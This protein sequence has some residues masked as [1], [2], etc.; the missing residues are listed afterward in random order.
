MKLINLLF[1]LVILTFQVSFSQVNTTKDVKEFEAIADTLFKYFKYDSASVYYRKAAQ[2]YEKEQDWLTC[3][4]NYRL[5]SNALLKAAKYDTALYYTNKALT[6][7]ETYFLK[8]NKDEMFEKSDV[9]INLADADEKKGKYEEELLYCKK[10]LALTLKT[11]SLASLRIANIWDKIGI[12]YTNLGNYSNALQFCASALYTKIKLLGE[13]HINVAESN[14]NIGTIY[15]NKGEY[16]KALAYLQKALKN[17]IATLGEQQPMTADIYINFGLVYYKKGEYDKA[18]EYYQNALKIHIATLGELHPDVAVNYYFIGN[19]YNHKGEYDKALEYYQKNLKKYIALLGER[20]PYFTNVYSHVGAVYRNKGEY[21]KALEYLQKAIIIGIATLGEQHPLIANFYNN[22]GLVYYMKGEYDKALVYY[23]NALKIFIAAFGEQHLDV[24]WSYNNIGELFHVKEL[25]D[26]SLEYFQKALK[27]RIAILGELNPFVAD[28][29]IKIGARYFNKGDYDTSLEYFQK[30]LKINIATLGEKHPDVAWN[31]NIIGKANRKKGE[32]FKALQNYQKALIANLTSFNDTSIY[33]NPKLENVLSKPM[34]LFSL[35]NKA[36]ALYQLFENKTKSYSDIETSLLI[37]ELAFQL[38]NNMRNEY[39]IENTKL[40]LSEN[41]KNYYSQALHVALEFDKIYPS[42]ENSTRTLEFMEKGKSAT[43]AARFNEIKAQHFAG[44]PDSLLEMEKDLRTGISFYTTQITNQKVQKNGYDTLKVNILENENFTFSLK[45]DSII[46]YFETTYPPY[47]EFK[48]ANKT[49]SIPEIQKSL[50]HNTAMLNYVVGDSSIFIATITDSFYKME[51]IPIDRGFNKL[52]TNYYRDIK[53]VETNSFLTNSQ[54]IY[55]KLVNPVKD[56]ISHKE[57]LI[58]IPDDYLYYVPFETLIDNS[59]EVTIQNEDYS[60]LPYLIKSHSITYHHSATLWYNSKKKGNELAAKRKINF[61]GFA[62]VFSKE[63]NNGVILSSN[64]S[65]I[66]TTG[67]KLV[68]RSISKDM[69]N[70]NP[71]PYSKDE[72]TSIVHL[73]EKRRKEAKA[74][75]YSEASEENFK[76]NAGNYS[77]IHVAS[78]GFSN[79]KEPDLSGIVF[80]QPTDT[81]NKE[82][83]ILYAGETYNLHLNADLIVLSSCESGLGKLV[84]GEGLQALSRGFLYAG[85]PNVIFSLWKALDKPTKDLMVQF[86][87]NVLD[88]KTY[89]ESLRQAKLNLINDPKTAFPHFWGGFVL[90]G[91]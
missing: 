43:M 18:L 85:T 88:G 39:N 79:D 28:S 69:K 47:Y 32:Y 67:D 41:T 14:S 15:A 8:N 33:S 56:Y 26:K 36:N 89:A 76:N 86:Y 34:L 3:V 44:I 87:S 25:H 81:L 72:V 17:S 46:N 13:D 51:E 83:G 1:F 20:H 55:E 53:T 48:Y 9:L 30:A 75:L 16:D 31:Y 70:F 21:D 82:N 29:Y 11:D 62:P 63:K 49:V 84:K 40:L 80:S 22:I 68:Y 45:L 19:V 60:K 38:T 77:F 66:D 37:Y 35:S 71:L 27:I 6:I 7:A 78:H 73:F 12:A 52:V 24:A 42:Q 65:A 4:K 58:V 90:V 57:H 74:Y 64:I 61:I 91:R 2:F 10:A 54:H 23:Q 5:T 50:D 59:S